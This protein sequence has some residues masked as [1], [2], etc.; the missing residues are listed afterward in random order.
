LS[1]PEL[2]STITYCLE[3]KYVYKLCPFQDVKQDYT[4]LGTWEGW[5]KTTTTESD[6]QVESTDYSIMKFANGLQCWNGPQ[7]SAQV[8]LQCG[9]DNEILSVEEPSTCVYQI[10]AQSYVACTPDVLAQARA[11]VAF[12]AKK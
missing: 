10:Q 4:S 12:W 6:G 11:E 7:R 1:K 5:G 9:T 2:E 8:V 3:Q